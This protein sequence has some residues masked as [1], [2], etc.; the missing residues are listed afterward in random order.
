MAFIVTVKEA[1]ALLSIS[2]G[3]V[4]QLIQSRT[5]PA[6]KVGNQWLIEEKALL[7]RMKNR[8][9][10]GRPSTQSPEDAKRYILMN[11]EHEVL[12]FTHSFSTNRFL[13]IDAI[14]D[15][16]RAP[17]LVTSPRGATGSVKA[18]ESWWCHRAI[19]V[20]RD[21]IDVKLRE[22]HF[23]DPSQIP[24][25]SLG[26]SLSDQYW[27]R[28]EDMD[29]SWE[30]INF[31]NNPFP[32]MDLKLASERWEWL[33][34]VGLNSPDNTSEGM[35]PKR[36][37]HQKGKTMLLKGSGPLGQEA[38]NEAVSTAL[39]RRLLGDGEFVP[40]ELART[41]NGVV[42]TCENFLNDTEEYVSA[43]TVRQLKHKPNHFNEYQHYVDC[44]AVVGVND[45]NSVLDKMIVCD[46]ILA[47]HDRHWR[48][49]GLVR[50]VETLSWRPAPLF[51]SGSSLWCDVDEG[52]LLAGNWSFSAKP[53]Y[54]DP[55]RQF[56]LVNDLSWFDPHSLDGFVEEARE[57]L[58]S[59]S[60]LARRLDAICGGIQFRI[61]RLLRQL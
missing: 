41:S 51:D 7:E 28:P 16:Q 58:I 2:V 12:G 20:S 33:S 44:C 24:F 43:F 8:P 30:E 35:L 27:I 52:A 49:F 36:W 40:Y 53:F 42:S 29:I 3:R 1:A 57:I 26:L 22:L 38:Y 50:D 5:L 56:R 47:N 9:K 21:G 61:D 54:D 45:A 34:D 18:L 6:E 19:P 60:A 14:Y 39:Y 59:N 31:F 10:A 37:I 25:E 17:L 55:N 15:H 32:D 13:E 23:E 46:D 4:H 11:R 48:N